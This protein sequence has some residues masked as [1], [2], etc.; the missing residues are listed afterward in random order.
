[1]SEESSNP[2]PAP[3]PERPAPETP[4][5][6]VPAME[7]EAAPLAATDAEPAAE[8]Q[9]VE[10]ETPD[11][12]DFFAKLQAKIPD[13]IVPPT[14]KMDGRFARKA[15]FW[16]TIAGALAGML[17]MFPEAENNYMGVAPRSYSTAGYFGALLGLAGLWLSLVS[18]KKI[19]RISKQLAICVTVVAV[20][21]FTTAVSGYGAAS[22]AG[23]GA[24]LGNRAQRSFDAMEQ[25]ARS[26]LAAKEAK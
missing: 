21:A 19:K 11:M 8:T 15:A 2:T 3:A 13:K 7:P 4:A 14:L 26:V 25:F 5:S 24:A 23:K 22:T 12:P 6:D 16:V 10:E 1:M 20:V 17:S 18:I 9:A